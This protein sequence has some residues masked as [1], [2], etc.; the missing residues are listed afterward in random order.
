MVLKTSKNH[1]KTISHE[2]YLDLFDAELHLVQLVWQ[3]HS[4][5]EAG[6]ITV[7]WFCWKCD[8]DNST[9]SKIK[10]HL[11]WQKY[12]ENITSWIL[13]M[14]WGFSQSLGSR[15][16]KESLMFS[17]PI[18]F[19]LAARMVFPKNR[20]WDYSKCPASRLWGCCRK[21]AGATLL[22]L[23]LSLCFFYLFLLPHSLCLLWYFSSLSCLG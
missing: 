12:I 16:T 6:L 2:S 13:N 17:T 5:G 10:I 15:V 19:L 21:A 3:N 8:D 22:L 20:F 1:T 9:L 14:L 18:S 11:T 4:T 23:S 7:G